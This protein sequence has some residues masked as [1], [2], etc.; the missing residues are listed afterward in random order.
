[1]SRKFTSR[2]C[3]CGVYLCGTW[4]QILKLR[5]RHLLHR[6]EPMGP[7][8]KV[9]DDDQGDEDDDDE[10]LTLVGYD[11]TEEGVERVETP[12]TRSSLERAGITHSTITEETDD[13]HPDD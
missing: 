11:L 7:A 3:R 6:H 13:H 10:V 5:V 12:V 4:P 9:D 1:V 2:A 8:P